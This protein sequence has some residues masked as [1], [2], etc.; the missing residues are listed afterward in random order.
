MQA[1]GVPPDVLV[2]LVVDT[3]AQPQVSCSLAELHCLLQPCHSLPQPLRKVQ[4]S[5][6]L[7]LQSLVCCFCNKPCT[8]L[9][10]S[11]TC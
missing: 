4:G 8:P 7:V 5:V 10:S 2:L 1:Q 11:M 6:L 3:P 9:S